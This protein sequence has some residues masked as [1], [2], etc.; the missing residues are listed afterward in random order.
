MIIK[1]KRKGLAVLVLA[2]LCIHTYLLMR[3]GIVISGDGHKYYDQA[4]VFMESGGFSENRFWL[5]SFYIFCRAIFIKLGIG[6]WGMYAFQLLLNGLAIVGFYFLVNKLTNIKSAYWATLL[7]VVCYPF[8]Y[9]TVHL[10]TESLFFSLII[11]FTG[12]VFI[13]RLKITFHWLIAALLLS[14]LVFTR[15]SGLYFLL[16]LIPVFFVLPLL[17][18]HAWASILLSSGM[19]VL[20][21]TIAGWSSRNT[22]ALDF[23]KP[24]AENHVLCYLPVKTGP[25]PAKQEA[26]SVW[27]FIIQHPVQSLWLM[28]KRFAT[29]WGLVRAH[30]S[31][32][33]N[34]MLILFFYPLYLFAFFGIRPLFFKNRVFTTFALSLFMVFT[35]S[36]MLTCDDWSNRFLLPLVPFIIIFAVT[37]FMHVFEGRSFANFGSIVH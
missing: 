14:M 3:M 36:V 37:G 15:P 16:A 10:I 21:F 13:T 19:L 30:Y 9:W 22:P 27:H 17:R 8:Q 5:Y 29:Y 32:S 1:E 7:L 35:L 2:W 31:W 4:L 24:F 28:A 6:Q 18:Q 12:F 33:H 11:F 25:Q 26:G 23:L 34:A 20:V